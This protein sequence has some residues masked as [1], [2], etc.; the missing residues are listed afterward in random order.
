MADLPL[1]IVLFRKTKAFFRTP[2][3]LEINTRDLRTVPYHLFILFALKQNV[4]RKKEKHTLQEE[5]GEEALKMGFWVD[6]G[7]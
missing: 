7:S 1:I 3:K 2:E 5:S 4:Q 6:S